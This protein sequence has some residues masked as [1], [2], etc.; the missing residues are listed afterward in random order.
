MSVKRELFIAE[1]RRARQRLFPIEAERLFLLKFA[2]FRNEILV[3]RRRE[4]VF[5]GFFRRKRVN[6][7]L[8][9][10][11]DFLNGV[12]AVFNAFLRTFL[13]ILLNQ[14]Q[15]ALFLQVFQLFVRQSRLILREKLGIRRVL[16]KSKVFEV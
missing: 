6:L 8:R 14:L 15:N 9:R 11:D 3:K 13:D 16:R 1:E 12:N 2:T 7:L 4:G 10:L 5:R